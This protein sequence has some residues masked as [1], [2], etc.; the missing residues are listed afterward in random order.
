MRYAREGGDVLGQ[1]VFIVYSKDGY[2]AV[3]QSSEGEPGKPVIVP[4]A[5]V[6]AS[7]TFRVPGDVD[8]R[9]EFHGVI[10]KDRL[11]GRFEGNG[12]VVDLMRRSS[13]WQ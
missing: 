3:L 11:I 8:A 9:G 6:G 1:E 10:S 2:F 13:Y 12:Q 5:L 7:V 4:V